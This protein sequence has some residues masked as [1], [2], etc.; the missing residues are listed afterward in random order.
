MAR[1]QCYVAQ[2]AFWWRMIGANNR[3]MAK[4]TQGYSSVEQ[5]LADA[6]SLAELAGRF[7]VE[8]SGEQGAAW[9]WTVVFAGQARA[10]SVVSYARRL[11]C[12]RSQ[13]RF[14]SGLILA[15]VA[16]KIL[17]LPRGKRLNA[18]IGN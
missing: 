18:G 12:L 6:M 5:A 17:V 14:E 10:Q 3:G 16:P 13:E 2:G 15:H 4:S 9:R 7:R 11:E 1:F 8:L